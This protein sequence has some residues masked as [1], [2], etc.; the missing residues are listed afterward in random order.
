MTTDER[1]GGGGAGDERSEQRKHPDLTARW[2][3]AAVTEHQ[4]AFEEEME[5]SRRTFSDEFK[6]F[7]RRRRI[8]QT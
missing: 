7:W 6:R 1:Q 4:V 2:L 5:R 8:E 3:R